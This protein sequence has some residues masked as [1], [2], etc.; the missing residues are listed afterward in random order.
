MTILSVFCIITVFGLLTRVAEYTR[1]DDY[2]FGSEWLVL[3]GIIAL[4]I[5]VFILPYNNEKH[6]NATEAEASTAHTAR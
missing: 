2:V 1:D 4:G 3:M 5:M 6:T